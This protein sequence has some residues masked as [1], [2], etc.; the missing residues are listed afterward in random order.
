MNGPR[1]GD[2][3]PNNQ[4]ARQSRNESDWKRK[5]GWE[6][7]EGKEGERIILDSMDAAEGGMDE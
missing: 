6:E 7:G 1:N 5:D 4:A 2:A 3:Q